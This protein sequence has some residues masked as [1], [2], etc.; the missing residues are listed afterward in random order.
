MFPLAM[1]EIL[2]WNQP[3]VEYVT[4]HVDC[5]FSN[6]FVDFYLKGAKL[7]TRVGLLQLLCNWLSFCPI[8]VTHFLHNG[9]NVP[10]VSFTIVMMK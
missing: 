5:F 9:A 10:Y 6:S 1:R 8:A 3:L 2:V 4:K 7:Q